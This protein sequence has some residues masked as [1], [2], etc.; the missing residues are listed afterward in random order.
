MKKTGSADGSTCQDP[1]TKNRTKQ[2]N[3]DPTSTIILARFQKRTWKTHGQRNER[4]D[5]ACWSILHIPDSSCYHHMVG[6]PLLCWIVCDNVWEC[7]SCD[8]R[9]P[10]ARPDIKALDNGDLTQISHAETFTILLAQ[11]ERIHDISWEY[12]PLMLARY[13]FELEKRLWSRSPAPRAAIPCRP[14]C[15]SVLFR[16]T[17]FSQGLGQHPRTADPWLT[18]EPWWCYHASNMQATF[19]KITWVEIITIAFFSRKLCNLITINGIRVSSHDD[20]FSL[21][22][23]RT[24]FAI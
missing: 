7:E 11:R 2:T 4:L 10:A 18:S 17:L 21:V 24:S 14:R 20:K 23:V 9:L 12:T 5:N 13:E 1:T 8:W 19:T 3:P 15:A 16:H 6:T 22:C